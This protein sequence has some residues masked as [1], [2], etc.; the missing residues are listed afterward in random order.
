MISEFVSNA[1]PLEDTFSRLAIAE[2]KSM[3]FDISAAKYRTNRND[4]ELAQEKIYST[5]SMTFQPLVRESKAMII[6]VYPTEHKCS[7]QELLSHESTELTE[8]LGTELNIFSR[9]WDR[10]NK[11]RKKTIDASTYGEFIGGFLKG[12]TN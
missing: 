1:V 2:N 10:F 5:R 9:N 4:F 8:L 12:F 6:G 7:I 3:D 11:Y